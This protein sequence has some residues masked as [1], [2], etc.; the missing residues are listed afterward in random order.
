VIRHNLQVRFGQ[1][2]QALE[3]LAE[4]D[5]MTW[6]SEAIAHTKADSSAP[7][8]KPSTLENELP[9]ILA[10]VEHLERVVDRERK[11]SKPETKPEEL[12]YRILND[13]AGRN[14]E[15]VAEDEGCT[16]KYV[17]DLRAMHNLTR[18]HGTALKRQARVA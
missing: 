7:K 12:R 1:A 2:L 5:A 10:L 16:Q 6:D 9:G 18:R 14:S 17:E 11:G 4:G 8:G 15:R 3:Y 13:Y